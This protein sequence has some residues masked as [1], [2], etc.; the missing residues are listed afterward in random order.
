[1]LETYYLVGQ[2]DTYL[3]HLYLVTK[4]IKINQRDT[5]DIDVCAQ[6][7]DQSL[8]EVE[9]LQAHVSEVQK[10][11]YFQHDIIFREQSIG[12]G[13][14]LRDTVIE[15]LLKKVPDY[16]VKPLLFQ[17]GP[18][19]DNAEDNWERRERFYKSAGFNVVYPEGKRAYA[20]VDLVKEL[21]VANNSGR[22]LRKLGPEEFGQFVKKLVQDQRQL[23]RRLDYLQQANERLDNRLFTC[24][25][26]LRFWRLL[27]ASSALLVGPIAYLM[28]V[29]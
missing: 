28:L 14:F 15:E 5:F 1:M 25:R 26:K 10:K 13:S 8:D 7:L 22:Y 23:T 11:V 6:R 21:K 17:P 27:F 2:R 12:L 16:R 24:W 20:A 3:T 29:G 19:R 4:E 18:G 9:N